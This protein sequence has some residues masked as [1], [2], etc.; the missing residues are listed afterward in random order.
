MG[1]R[2]FYTAI[3]G[4]LPY[5]FFLTPFLACVA[6]K[7]NVQKNIVTKISKYAMRSLFLKFLTQGYKNFTFRRS[8][9]RETNLKGLLAR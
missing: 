7:Q 9:E 6:G 2:F 5:A 8:T 3:T 1:C 4:S